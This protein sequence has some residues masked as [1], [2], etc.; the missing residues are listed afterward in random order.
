VDAEG[1]G[2]R[3]RTE[4]EPGGV[5]ACARARACVCEGECVFGG[6]YVGGRLAC[7]SSM[8]AQEQVL[9][10]EREKWVQRAMAAENGLKKDQGVCGRVQ[11]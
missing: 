2:S 1:N 10:G 8:C 7:C 11:I 3:E 4:E 9:P 5:C 6:V